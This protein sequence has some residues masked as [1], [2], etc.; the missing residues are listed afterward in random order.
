[1]EL[2]GSFTIE[3]A[4]LMP[5]ILGTIVIL[6]YTSFFLHDRAVIYEGA[7]LLANKYTNEQNMSDDKI[8]QNLEKEINQIINEQV[9]CTRNISTEI[10]V[11]DKEIIVASTGEFYF[12]NMYVAKAVFQKQGFHILVTKTMKRYNPVSFIRNCRKVEKLISNE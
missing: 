1:M 9:I 8:K 12:P 2:R 3:A 10:T 4:L 6:I 5:I 11:K 7:I